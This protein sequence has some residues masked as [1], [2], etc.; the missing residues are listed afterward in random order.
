M[1]YIIPVLLAVLALYFCAG[2]MFAA[3]FIA[4]LLLGALVFIVIE[5]QGWLPSH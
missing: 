2:V 1:H 4:I 3:A 5:T